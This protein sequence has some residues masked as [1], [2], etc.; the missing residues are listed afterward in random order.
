MAGM[1]AWSDARRRW[2]GAICLGTAAGLLI[3][4]Q[5]GLEHRLRGW[6]FLFY[7]L[8]CLLLTLAAIF[9][10]LLDIRILQRRTRAAH[11]EL[12]EQTFGDLDH[13]PKKENKAE[14]P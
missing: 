13:P 11:Q 5:T 8:V 9:L 7:W 4:G 1:T 10:A 14:Q 3:W 2:L 12:M 6:G